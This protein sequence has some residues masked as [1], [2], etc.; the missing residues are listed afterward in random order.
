[1]LNPFGVGRTT[2]LICVVGSIGAPTVSIEKLPEG[3]EMLRAL[4]LLE[5]HIGQ[6]I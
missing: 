3:T 6:R 4:R 5:E 1:M 2:R